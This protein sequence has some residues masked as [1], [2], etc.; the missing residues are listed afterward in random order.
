MAGGLERRKKN[1]LHILLFVLTLLTTT[2]GGALQTGA[3]PFTNPREMVAG[4]PFSF[5][6]MAILLAH[7]MGHYLTARYHGVRATLPF[8]IPAPPIP[9]FIGTFG[10]FIRME[11]PPQDRRSLFDVAAAGPLAGLALA[12]PAVVL[13]LSLSTVSPATQ[14]SGGFAL[15][16][17]LLLAFLREAVLGFVPDH[18]DVII[19][20]IGTAGWVG[21]FVTAMNLLPVGQLDGGH[22]VYALFGERYIWVSRL[23]LGVIL[24]LGLLRLWDGWIV[25]G[26]ILLFLGVRHP[27]PL[28][29][30]TRLDPKRIFLGWVVL[31]VLA[32]TFIPVPVSFQEPKA[33]RERILPEPTSPLLEAKVNGGPP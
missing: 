19:H 24:A 32:V 10:A 17:S 25:W 1:W 8:F 12:I 11:S 5:T 14:E 26:L 20:P 16:S 6:L 28:D 21:L 33:R 30:H 3:N 29:P 27:P 13:G 4:L 18:L 15:G 2:A 31:A 23:G 7:E 9:F 22:V